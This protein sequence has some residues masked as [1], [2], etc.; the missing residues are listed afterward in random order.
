MDILEFHRTE[1]TEFN[2]TL[3]DI[4]LN[5]TALGLFALENTELQINPGDYVAELYKSPKAHGLEVPK[6]E[7]RDG[8]TYI[9]FHPANW[10]NQLEGCIAPGRRKDSKGVY[11][12]KWAWDTIMGKLTFPCIFRIV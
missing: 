6:L 11:Q 5:G 2:A 12:S 4:Y 9:E 1:S 3:S 10:P 8:R 7:D